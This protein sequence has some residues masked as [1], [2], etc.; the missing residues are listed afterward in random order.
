MG[1]FLVT[2]HLIVVVLVT[3]PM[4]IAPIVAGRAIA[5]R[6][7]DAARVAGN[8]LLACGAGSVLAAGLGAL[9]V[10]ASGR[11]T[12]ATPWVIISITVYV[13]VLVLALGYVAPA[14]RKAAKL[15]RA[16][17]KP[18]PG[19]VTRLPDDPP[20]S[21][22]PPSPPPVAPAP[23]TDDGASLPALEADLRARQRIDE[24]VSRIT[25]AGLLIGLG[26]VLLVVLMVV[27]PFGA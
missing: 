1:T 2:L 15:I 8:V 20:R 12:F 27:K 14:I 3:G 5:R 17:P 4:V 21:S 6:N 19:N 10:G 25:G 22:A 13:L 23:S 18:R 26:V 16:L 7:A 24:L 11:Y 9:A